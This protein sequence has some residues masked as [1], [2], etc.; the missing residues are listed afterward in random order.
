MTTASTTTSTTTSTT[1][2]T[3]G[4]GT[5]GTPVG[6]LAGVGGHSPP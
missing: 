1:P 3:L 5:E 6:I 2:S 4:P